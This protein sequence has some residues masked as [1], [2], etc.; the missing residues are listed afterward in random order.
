MLALGRLARRRRKPSSDACRPPL[1]AP[2]RPTQGAPCSPL[3]RP[4]Q[5]RTCSPSRGARVVADTLNASASGA[6]SCSLRMRLPLPT[7]GR[8]GQS[9]QCGWQARELRV[10]T[11]ALAQRSSEQRALRRPRAGRPR[12]AGAP[13]PPV[14]RTRHGGY[15][16][17]PQA[18]PRPAGR[19]SGAVDV[20]HGALGPCL[21]PHHSAQ[22]RPVPWEGASVRRWQPPRPL[23]AQGCF[24]RPPSCCARRLLRAAC[25]ARVAVCVYVGCLLCE[26]TL[27]AL[28]MT[29]SNAQPCL[30]RATARQQRGCPLLRTAAIGFAA[31]TRAVEPGRDLLGLL[32]PHLDTCI[33]A[34]SIERRNRP[35]PGSADCRKGVRMHGTIVFVAASPG[36]SACHPASRRRGRGRTR[37]QLGSLCHQHFCPAT[38]ACYPSH[39]GGGVPHAPPAWRRRWRRCPHRPQ[40]LDT[41]HCDTKGIPGVSFPGQGERDRSGRAASRLAPKAK[42]TH[43]PQPRSAPLAPPI[44][45]FGFDTA[46]VH[47]GMR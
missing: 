33:W 17:I 23:R 38:A 9:A 11:A 15:P 44:V 47:A 10:R 2:C 12:R 40:A 16:Q 25:G 19:R 13:L 6:A 31:A 28:T 14:P 5:V 34:S 32:A 41:P 36:A 46:P 4:C 26:Q 7:P 20:P 21:G 1:R 39:R 27:E 35:L 22:R 45:Q 30:G 3:Q 29:R 24:A 18:R 8:V 42:Q 37:M 43:G